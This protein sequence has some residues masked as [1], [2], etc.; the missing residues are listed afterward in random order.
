MIH[1]MSEL[2]GTK[3]KTRRANGHIRLRDIERP[4]ERGRQNNRQRVTDKE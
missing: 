2:R 1:R 3:T 4:T